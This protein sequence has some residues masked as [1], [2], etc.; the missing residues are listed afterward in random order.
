MEKKKLPDTAWETYRARARRAVAVARGRYVPLDASQVRTET[1]TADS[2]YAGDG[3]RL[4]ETDET[5]L[6]GK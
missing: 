3:P 5:E 1:E 4:N 6:A 2:P